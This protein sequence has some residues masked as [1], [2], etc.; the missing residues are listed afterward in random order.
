V[1][2]GQK[3]RG[4]GEGKWNGFGGKLE[5]GESIEEAARR[6]MLE[7]SGVAVS[8]LQ[9]AGIIHFEFEGNPEI[10]EVHIFRGREY[11]GEPF[12]TEEM[13]PQWFRI[14][15]IPFTE[16]WPDDEHWM[17]LFF[18]GKK[19]QGKFLFGEGNSILQQELNEIES[20]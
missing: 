13:I 5:K 12:E 6:E 18:A 15:E 17:P 10:L 8:A 20:F 19:F 7:E 11:V 14:D 1:L 9:K 16:M 3:K 2:L 4:F